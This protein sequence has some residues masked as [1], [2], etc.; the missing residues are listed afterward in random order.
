M[1]S[2]LIV[3]TSAIGD[4]VQTF[5]AVEYLRMR[6]PH[7]QIHWVLEKGITP[8]IRQLRMVDSD[9][10]LID[11]V[12]EVDT[13][14][15]VRE[16]WRGGMQQS[17][18]HLRSECYDLIFDLQG[19]IKSGVITGL[20]RGKE[21]VGFDWH[22]A[23]EKLNLL[24]TDRRF[25]FPSDLNIQDKYL[26]LVQTYLQDTAPFESRGIR[27][28][29]TLSEQEKL[30][31]ILGDPFFQRPLKLM[32]AVGSRWKNKRITDR[33]LIRL[34]SEGC[35]LAGASFLLIYGNSDEE[36]L[37]RKLM[38]QFPRDALAV[39]ELSLPL[40]QTLMSRVEGVLAV[41]S[42]ALHFAGTTRTPSFSFF[43]PTSAKVFKPRKDEHVAFQG[44]CPYG[45]IFTKQCSHLRTCATGACLNHVEWEEIQEPFI[46]WLDRLLL[47][48]C[49]K[50]SGPSLGFPQ[51][52]LDQKRD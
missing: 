19:N 22:S 6:F 7:A 33:L 44:T 42:A 4:V 20:A 14:T 31:Q 16:L 8:L 26:G 39:G 41:D 18:R 34:L 25:G 48:P 1:K 47:V 30:E 5:P 50:L 12:I 27:F 35:K 36:L 38:E 28:Q 24:A 40:W 9:Q 45:K 3:R 23:R 21:K 29:L 10:P 17:I 52:S 15:G 32:I 43:G 13:K 2:I 37:A 11:Q 51:R 49:L 46:R